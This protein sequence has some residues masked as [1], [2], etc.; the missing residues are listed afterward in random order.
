LQ[1]SLTWKPDDS[2]TFTIYGLA[3]RG[4]TAASAWS[5][6]NDGNVELYTDPDYNGQKTEQYQLGYQ[7]EHEFDNGLTFRQNAR[8]GDV[9]L[10]AHY[11]NRVFVN[12][13]NTWPTTAVT[14]SMRTYQ[15]DNQLEAK[16]DTG[17]ISHTLL[18]GL[19]YT[20]VTSDFAMGSGSILPG[21][22]TNARYRHSPPSPVAT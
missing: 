21:A 4:E 7:L 10:K 15:I 14:D 22:V 8:A 11:L 1:P 9:D 6:L 16:F 12:P 17:A 13:D 3:Q 19:D 18:S 2:T 5:F 20:W